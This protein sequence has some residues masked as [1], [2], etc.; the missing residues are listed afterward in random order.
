MFHLADSITDA[1]AK[2]IDGIKPGAEFYKFTSN[3]LG[4][5]PL[6]P[7]LRGVLHR[8]KKPFEISIKAS[9]SFFVVNLFV[10]RTTVTKPAV[11]NTLFLFYDALC[12]FS[13]A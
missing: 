1:Y 2:Y 12:N 8:R 11:H 4:C 13:E 10:G 5:F 6:K 9:M 3:I 7:Y